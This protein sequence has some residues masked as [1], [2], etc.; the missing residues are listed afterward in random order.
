[1][2]TAHIVK[3]DVL[4]DVVQGGDE[5]DDLI[6]LAHRMVLRLTQQTHKALTVGELTLCGLVE[7]AGELGEDFHFAVLGKVQTDAARCLFHGLCLG[8]A[9]D[10]G[11][12]KT[13]V[14]SRTLAGEEQVALKEDL[15]VCDGNNVRRDV[16]GNVARLRFNNRQCRHAAAAECIGKM[17]RALQQTGMQVE[18]VTRIRFTTRGTLQKQ[19]QCTVRNGVL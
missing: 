11:N 14:N 7:V 4:H 5:R 13:D 1:M 2:E 15:T 12:R 18:N 9:A 3:R 6:V 17:R 19:A 16:S 8:I 10:T